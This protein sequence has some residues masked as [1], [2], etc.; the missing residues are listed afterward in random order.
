MR[1]ENDNIKIKNCTG[2][3]TAEEKVDGLEDTVIDIS[4]NETVMLS[5]KEKRLILIHRNLASYE[6]TSH[7]LIYI[8][9]ETLK[10]R[11]KWG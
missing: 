5:E 1:K 2:L 6:T 9:F 7:G 10:K 11:V 4:H 3:D 8:N